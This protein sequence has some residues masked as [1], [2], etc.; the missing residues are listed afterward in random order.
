MKKFLAMLICLATVLSLVACGGGAIGEET[1][2]GPVPETTEAKDYSNF[3]GIVADPKGWYDAF[4]A[5]PIANDQMTEQELRQL[6]AD[7]FK[8]NLTFQWTPNVPIT[9]TYELLDRYSDVA[10]P[11]GIAYSGLCYA[12]GVKNATNGTIYKVL[13]YYDPETGT[14]DIEAMGENML[15]II[16][17]ACANGA[18]QGWNRVSPDYGVKSMSCSVHET[19]VVIV[20][21]YT[22]EPHT[23]NYNWISRTASN[24]II[25]ANGD[26]VMYE[27]L[28]LT[29]MA[30]GLYSS[31]SWHMM[32]V[33]QDPVVVR[34]PDGKIDPN[35]SYLH[36][37]EQG[38][39]GTKN[40]TYNYEQSNGVTIRPLGTVDKKYTFKDLL[41]K[42]YIPFTLKEFTGEATVKAGEAWLGKGSYKIENGSEMDVNTLF[43]KS[44]V[45]NY[46]LCTVQVQVKAPDGTVLVCY[47]PHVNTGPSTKEVSLQPALLLERLTPYAD[48]KN[49]IHI[50]AQLSNG[51]K[52]EAFSTIL[53]ID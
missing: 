36:V 44:L 39:G 20:G 6:A 45:T 28:A 32:M 33:S 10:L 53:K 48:G 18:M 37:H 7:A 24:E 2:A 3:A 13:N 29:H 30:D 41:E 51:E 49:T 14:L 15:N 43:S 17:S 47:N 50:Y 34:L 23:Y 4:M 46:S 42:G 35:A 52:L 8:A 40:D 12:T 11:T 27:S 31:S 5:L 1:P 38:A 9:Y 16:S 21:P 19:N 26:E 22:Y 25:A